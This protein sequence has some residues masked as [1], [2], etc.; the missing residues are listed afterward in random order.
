LCVVCTQFE[1]GWGCQLFVLNDD[2]GEEKKSG[3]VVCVI[4]ESVTVT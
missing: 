3:E 4:N 1:F 2:K